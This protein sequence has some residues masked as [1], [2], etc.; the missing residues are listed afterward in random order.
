MQNISLEFRHVKFA[1]IFFLYDR[2]KKDTK[3]VWK[4][5]YVGNE[6]V[7]SGKIDKK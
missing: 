1:L 5:H 2:E 7:C 4:S 6:K 3:R